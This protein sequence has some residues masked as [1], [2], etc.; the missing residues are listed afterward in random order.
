MK[1]KNLFVLCILALT[2][3]PIT[4]FSQNEKKVEKSVYN[5]DGVFSGAGGKYY[6]RQLDNE[7][8]WYGEEDA[9]SPSWSNVAHGVIKGNTITLKWADVPKGEVMQSGSLVIRIKSNDE[10]ELV[11]QTGEFFATDSWTRIPPK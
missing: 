7:L 5:L 10:L 6:L 8:L 4:S 2:L 11:K 1:L 9:V 3:T